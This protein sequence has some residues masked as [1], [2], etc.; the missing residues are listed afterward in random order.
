MSFL[1]GLLVGAALTVVLG[2]PVA[3]MVLKRQVARTRAAERR[4]RSAE[5]MAEIGAMTGGLAH[6]IKNPLSTLG[7]NAQLLEEAIADIDV[8]EPDKGR[9]LRRT[10]VLR[11]EAD[12]LR[13]TLSDF[14]RFAG[15]IR[16]DK[17][18]ADLNSIIEELIDFYTPQAEAQRIRLRTELAGGPI[19]AEV[20]VGL[21]KQALLN[22][23][24]N[25]VQAMERA[26]READG[27]ARH[28]PI[29]ELLLRTERGTGEEGP[30]VRVHVI[31]TGPGIPPDQ[32]ERIFTPYFSTTSGGT[33][34]G[35]PTTRRLVEEHSGHLDVRSEVGRGSDFIIRL[36]EAAEALHRAARPDTF[37]P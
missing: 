24:I 23:M 29:G 20:D 18:R 4:A 30:E 21:F 27:P 25:A 19:S 26:A 36:P 8:P 34:L 12:R 31:D 2:V 32:I 16:L 11:R 14:L 22:L 13:D 9:L 7:L 17:Q 6:E 35:L 15:E 37:T 5:R 3:N 10:R 28:G 1:A 33:G